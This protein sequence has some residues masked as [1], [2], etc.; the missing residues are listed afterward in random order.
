MLQPEINKYVELVQVILYL[1]NEQEIVC[2]AVDNKYYCDAITKYFSEYRNHMVI[3]ITKNLIKM[4]NFIH[5]KPLRAVLTLDYIL[6]DKDDF[7]YEWAK[8]VN[9]FISDTDFNLFFFNQNE[10]YSK[11]LNQIKSYN[12]DKWINFI[13]CYFKKQPENFKLIICPIAGNYGFNIGS[14]S[15]IVKYLPLITNPKEEQGLIE[16]LAKNI[17]HEYAHCFVNNVV[18]ANKELLFDFNDFFRKHTN[19][20]NFYNTDYAIMNEYWVRAFAIRFMEQNISMFPY[21]DIQR[22]YEYQKNIFIFI[23]KF[24]DLLKEFELSNKSFEQFYL[25]KIPNIKCL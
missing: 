15:Y 7:R 20:L 24:V 3:S 11:L 5:A 9:E 22:E 19:M 21:F 25:S 1:A 18:E 14:I 4:N 6:K 12:F 8:S 17:A 16:K 10:Y 13:E 23:E 2:Q